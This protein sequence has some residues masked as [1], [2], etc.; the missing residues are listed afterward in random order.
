MSD[1]DRMVSRKWISE[2]FQIH[3]DTIRAWERM[4]RIKPYNIGRS[5]RYRYEDVMK[6]VTPKQPAPKEGEI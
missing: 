5:V 6:L 4:G 3:L 1:K 2:N